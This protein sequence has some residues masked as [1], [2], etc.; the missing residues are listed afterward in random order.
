M[1]GSLFLDEKICAYLAS[2]TKPLHCELGWQLNLAI[3]L[4][5]A[6][7]LQLAAKGGG[8][9]GVGHAPSFSVTFQ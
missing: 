4:R 2:G 9:R 1:N 7:K 5:C 6:G 8:R 3:S